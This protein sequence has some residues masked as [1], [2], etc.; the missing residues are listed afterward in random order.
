MRVFVQAGVSRCQWASSAWRA[1][2][3]AVAPVEAA[4]GDG[5]DA[6]RVRWALCSKFGCVFISQ[7]HPGLL[8]NHV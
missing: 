4:D 5:W 7:N 1:C 3:S 2:G 6:V 8:W